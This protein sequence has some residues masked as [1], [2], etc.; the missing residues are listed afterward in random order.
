MLSGRGTRIIGITGGREKEK[1]VREDSRSFWERIERQRRKKA[2]NLGLMPMG[3]MS[4][5]QATCKIQQ[6]EIKSSARLV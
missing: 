5:P 1:R 4:G 6:E 3:K 2:E